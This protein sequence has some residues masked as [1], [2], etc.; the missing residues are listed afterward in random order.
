MM[1]KQH[2]KLIFGVILFF[3][4][5]FGF[6]VIARTFIFPLDNI[7][8]VVTLPSS[9][10]SQ[11]GIYPAD[12][13]YVAKSGSDSN[14]G[15]EAQPWLTI[16]KAASTLVAGDTVY[17]RQGTYK[18]RVVP[19][20]S[21]DPDNWITYRISPGETVIIDGTGI[22]TENSAL[23]YIN[24]IS[25]IEVDGFHIV[26][27][28]SF[29]VDVR[30]E[31]HYIN[32]KNLVI[33]DAQSSGIHLAY[34]KT[35]V[36]DK[37]SNINIDRCDIS[38]TNKNGDQEAISLVAVKYFEIKNSTVHNVQGNKE[39][40]DCKVGT[41][42]G[43]IYNNEIHFAKQ[44]IYIDPSGVPSTNINIFNNRIYNNSITGIALASEGRHQPLSNLNIYN[45]LIYGN[46]RGFSVF[47]DSFIKTNIYFM[48]NTLYK[49]GTASEINLSGN[50]QEYQNCVI[51]N[52]IIFGTSNT[53]LISAQSSNGIVI[54]HNLFYSS[55]R[56]NPANR[57]GT[58]YIQADP[59]M[60]NPDNADFRLQNLSPAI[61]AGS[62]IEEPAY[63]YMGTPRP[64]GSGYDIGAF[65]YLF[66]AG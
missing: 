24:H 25:Y 15:T 27:S 60:I 61:D 20:H 11:S 34:G 9:P 22:S 45:N 40:I 21:G 46:V 32:L 54:D 37:I 64:Q 55:S 36:P 1:L 18:E 53:L 35:F 16:Q 10:S 51:S 65:E 42:Y 31:S 43:A 19:A 14:P 39:G 26:H 17:V 62:G 6:A 23:F 58:N 49:N 8:S 5:L 7:S 41:S 44:G 30:G 33:D 4:M 3:L 56:Y 38:N 50:G 59:M 13:Y 29:A 48:N 57:Y 66:S 12:S 52:N 47:D 2:F 63:D 28:T